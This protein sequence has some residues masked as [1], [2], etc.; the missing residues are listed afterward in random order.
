[1]V[2]CRPADDLMRDESLSLPFFFF[3][4]KPGGAMKKCVPPC[5]PQYNY[6]RTVHF[7]LHACLGSLRRWP[8]FRLGLGLIS[9]TDWDRQHLCFVQF[10]QSHANMLVAAT[11]TSG[12]DKTW[13]IVLW[14]SYILP[15]SPA[16]T[17]AY[18]EGS[19]GL[20][21]HGDRREGD[22]R[23]RLGRGL[24]CSSSASSTPPVR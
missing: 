24:A 4:L 23:G 3:Q 19:K 13:P 10:S 8:R 12:R 21:H 16:F 17:A 6:V 7:R 15:G 11:T 5:Q 1:M 20:K 14:V 2:A 9:C 18:D 22:G